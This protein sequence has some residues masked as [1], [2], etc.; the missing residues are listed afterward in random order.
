MLIHVTEIAAL[1]AQAWMDLTQ[2]T[3][4]CCAAMAKVATGRSDKQ[5]Q[6]PVLTKSFIV[7]SQ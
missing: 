4:A 1:Q 3:Q 6:D 7:R 2:K 5:T